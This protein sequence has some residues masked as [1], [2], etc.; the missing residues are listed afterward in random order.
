M[1]QHAAKP[2]AIDCIFEN[3]LGFMLP[4][5][6]VSARG[7]ADLARAAIAELAEAYK[8]ATATELEFVGRILGFNIV[9]MDNLR[10][11]MNTEMSDTKTQFP[12]L[13]MVV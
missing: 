1:T 10:L 4:F 13:P 2:T 3:I 8:A 11:S 9:A 7:N 6:L 5:F 12:L